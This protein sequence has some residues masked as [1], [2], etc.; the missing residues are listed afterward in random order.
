LQWLVRRMSPE[1]KRRALNVFFLQFQFWFSDL[2][3]NETPQETNIF[4]RVKEGLVYLF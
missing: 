4:N 2:L 3:I 1:L